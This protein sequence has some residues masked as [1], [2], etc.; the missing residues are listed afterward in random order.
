MTNKKVIAVVASAVVIGG[1]VGGN[2][3]ADK[4][5]KSLYSVQQNAPQKQFKLTKVNYNMGMLSGDAQWEAEVINDPCK[6]EDKVLVKGQDHIR[7]GLMGYEIHSDIYVESEEVKKLFNNTAFVTVDAHLGWSGQAD[8]Q[9]HSPSVVKNEKDF[10][11]DW[12]GIDLSTKAKKVKQDVEFKDLKVM[13][14]KF[15]LHAGQ[16]NFYLQNFV[17]TSD[18]NYKDKLAAGRSE[19]SIETMKFSESKAFTLNRLKFSNVLS[20]KNDQFDYKQTI[21][22]G[23]G[24]LDQYT[25]NQFVLNTE[26]N[27]ISKVDAQHAFETMNHIQDVCLPHQNQIQQIIGAFQPLVNKGFTFTSK[28]NALELNHQKLTFDLDG[29]L[30]PSMPIDNAPLQ[31]QL[32]NNLMF[33]INVEIE[34]GFIHLFQPNLSDTEMRQ[35]M[36]DKHIE[37]T[38]KSV[39]LTGKFENGQFN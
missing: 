38:D 6:P 22:V 29:A 13:M 9:A 32:K 7:R 14:P 17:Y 15:E 26:L 34:K 39:K 19:I 25:V 12:A 27:H 24:Q 5:L 28:Q 3:Y 21:S 4:T 20:D 10:K 11:L 36:Q 30:K 16:Y 31:E 1:I 35:R 37:I 8:I 33:N 2:V 18:I 23:D